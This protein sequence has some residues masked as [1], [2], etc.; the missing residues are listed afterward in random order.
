MLEALLHH[1]L[2]VFHALFYL[3]SLGLA[4]AFYR[5]CPS[6]YQLLLIASILHL[7][8]LG[9]R[10]MLLTDIL[11]IF[12]LFRHESVFGWISMLHLLAN[13]LLLLAVV[14]GRNQPPPR[15]AARDYRDDDDWD[16]PAPKP[17]PKIVESTDIHEKR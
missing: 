13:L 12:R 16:K 10:L 17:N 15:R 11:P 14:T 4:L 8:A 7:I 2:D 6:A 1:I 3:V 9:V 5:R